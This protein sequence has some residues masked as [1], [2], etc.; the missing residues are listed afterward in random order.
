MGVPNRILRV[1]P[2]GG[3]VS[4]LIQMGGGGGGAGA[5]GGGAP[6]NLT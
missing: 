2:G 4:A 1:K 5:G 3:L 6:V